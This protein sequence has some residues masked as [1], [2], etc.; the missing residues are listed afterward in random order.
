[1][2]SVAG[3]GARR[4]RG[5]GGLEWPSVHETA[6]CDRLPS[7]CRLQ[8][9]DCTRVATSVAMPQISSADRCRTACPSTASPCRA[10]APTTSSSPS[11]RARAPSAPRR[12]AWRTSSSTSSSR[13]ARSTTTTARS[14]RPP[15][16]WAASLNA[17]TCHDLVAFHITVRAEARHARRSTC[18]P[19][20]SGAR[21]STPEELD[22]ERGV[23]IQEIQRY[24][25][26]PSMVA[27]YLIDRA[28]FGDHPL[29][30]HRARARGAPAQLHAR[31][32]RRLPRAPLVGR[33]RRRVP[34]RQPRARAG[35]RRRR[36]S[37]FGALPRRCPRPTPYE[38]A[39]AFAP[40]T[41]V[42]QRDTNQSHLRM[43][44][45]PDVDVDRPARSARRS[46]IYS[47]LLGGSMG[48]RLFDEIREK[49]GLCYSVYA[50]DHAFADVADPAARLG[51]RL[52]QV[53]RGLHA[54]ARDRRRAAPPTGRPRRRSSAPGPTPPAAAC[55]PSRTPN[56]VARY[57]AN[58]QIVFGEA[59]D[60]DEAIAALDGVTFDEVARSPRASTRQLAVACVG[61]HTADEF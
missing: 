33:A 6:A 5:R 34:R 25:D 49:R 53:R 47:T 20:S 15:S 4:A 37:C 50:V 3:S 58:Q 12:T 56:A 16:A 8:G 18:S 42:E 11:T 40:Q 31:G 51:P 7:A 23:V 32:H 36:T 9:H 61:P 41:L 19:T 29:G 10:R 57:A 26:Q 27:E 39:P 14:T 48:S 43:I 13:A 24:K 35:E 45:R 21:R 55:W 59:I 52:G 44:Y 60:P 38:P 22:R 17:Y 28:A 54:H 46:S 1:M 30:P 2:T